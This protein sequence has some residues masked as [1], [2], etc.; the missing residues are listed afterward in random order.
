V[1]RVGASSMREAASDTPTTRAPAARI[2]TESRARRGSRDRRRAQG[3]GARR[4]GSR[5]D[6][7]RLA[8]RLRER[9][10]WARAV[11][12]SPCIATVD[13]GR[14][15]S[16]PDGCATSTAEDRP[17]IA[18]RKA[19]AEMERLWR[20]DIFDPPIGSHHP[21][22]RE[23]LAVIEGIIVRN[24]W[25]WATPYRG[26]SPPQWCGFTAGDAW[27]E[28]GLDPTWLP[29]YFA[30][31]YRLKL[32]ATYERFDRKSKDNPR[33]QGADLR[34]YVDLT[35]PLTI[36][37]RAGD[38]VIVGDGNPSVGDHVTVCMGYANGVFDTVAGNAGGVG[39]NG[40]RREGISRREYRV[41][42]SGYRPM[43]MVRPAASD[44]VY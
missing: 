22:A 7:E 15:T 36:E 2:Q 32:W 5:H 30:S 27:A 24:G 20:M 8:A 11:N 17:L 43:W 37:P 9:R 34:L 25:A 16:T 29:A 1:M 44:I 3:M 38:I 23:C 4:Q 40:D 33:P 42:S 10:Y 21:R 26:N 39:P 31:T 12:R 14:V 19:A 28:A 6:P 41:G 13:A 18:G 35:K